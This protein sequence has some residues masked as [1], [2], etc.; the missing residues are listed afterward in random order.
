MNNSITVGAIVIIA[1]CSVLVLGLESKEISV[2]AIAALVG[3]LTGS[4]N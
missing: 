1:V 4:S 2:A 3:Y